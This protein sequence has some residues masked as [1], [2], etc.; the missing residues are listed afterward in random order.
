MPFVTRY[1]IKTSLMFFVAALLCALLLVLRPFI[2]LPAFVVGLTPV[3][4]HL[5][6]VGWV[7]QIIIGVAFWMFPKFTKEQPRGSEML[8]WSTYILLNT[9]LLLR[10]VAEP[11]NAVQMWMGWGWLL[12]LAALLQ[13]LGGFAFV[14]N[15][16][17]RIKER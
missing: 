13:W 3:Y 4:F 1:F 16:W 17:P 14:I 12:A 8:A 7:T 5:F 11:A 6:M 15:T 9:G 2:V 10:A